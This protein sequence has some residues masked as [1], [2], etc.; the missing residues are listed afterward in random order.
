MPFRSFGRLPAVPVARRRDA[1]G[2]W[3]AQ[4]GAADVALRQEVIGQ[5]L[6]V[7]NAP[8]FAGLFGPDALAEAPIAAVVG[9]A[10]IAGT[11]DRLCVGADRVQIV[12]FK[13][14][15]VAPR[16]L[17]EVPMAHVRQMAAYVAALKVIFPDR[18]I[19][20][21]LL[22]T[23]APRLITLPSALLAAHK[24]GFVPAQEN[25]PLPPVEPGEPAS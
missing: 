2:R 5:A 13:T 20:A 6:R 11:V 12:D 8:D 21:G 25:L 18:A 23:S 16:T 10:V 14:G 19:E 1:A 7:I 15:R 22:Y 17:A 4:Q 3:L 9:E 24:P